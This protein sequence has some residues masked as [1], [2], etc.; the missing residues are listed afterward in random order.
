VNLISFILISHGRR[1]FSIKIE[2]N[3]GGD[4]K[5]LFSALF[6]LFLLLSG[7]IAVAQISNSNDAINKS[8]SLRYQ[9]H[10]LGRLYI[11]IGMGVDVDRS[12]RLLDSVIP[13]Y[14]RRLIELKS[15]APT[16]EIK[17]TYV[18]LEKAWGGY[19]DLLIG[20]KPS[21]DVARKV[22]EISDQV[23]IIANKAT[24]QL[25]AHT[26]GAQGGLVNVSGRQRM[27]SQR[28]GKYS[29]AITWGIA[30]ANALEEINKDKAEFG[31]KLDELAAAPANTPAIRE[32]L[33][34]ARQQWMFFDGALTAKRVNVMTIATTSERLLE[35]M[36]NIVG[37]YEKLGK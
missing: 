8:G 12:K 9:A 27:L 18:A 35:A 34:L 20:A 26:G 3:I 33:A 36:D 17:E 29:Q 16:P 25:V 15:Y 31:Q 37:M 19:K 32:E 7:D 22:V 23:V 6:G 10:R 13:I 4:M 1:C 21:P 14:D 11:Q 5:S 30:P 2:K 28:M 24:G